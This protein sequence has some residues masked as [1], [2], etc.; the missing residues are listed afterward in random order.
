LLVEGG[1]DDPGL[2]AEPVADLPS[3]EAASEEVTAGSLIIT[4]LPLADE[5]LELRS[6]SDPSNLQT[7]WVTANFKFSTVEA[8]QEDPKPSDEP[9]SEPPSEEPAI[10]EVKE[11]LPV[12][13]SPSIPDP[14]AE[15]LTEELLAEEYAFSWLEASRFVFS[16]TG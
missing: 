1:Q 2:A 11:E 16:T 9:A 6:R 12:E 15:E 3:E 13:E 7:E 5:R 8:V 10:E 4:K 14:V